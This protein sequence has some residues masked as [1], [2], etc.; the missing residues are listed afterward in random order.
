MKRTQT[1]P[2]TLAALSGLFDDTVALFHRLTA[3]AEQVHGQGGLSAARRGV[4]RSLDRLGPQTVPQMARARPVSR[5]LIQSLVNE[6]RRE[7]Y[8]ELTANP[9]HRRSS[10]V[11]LTRRGKVLVDAMGSR[12]LRLLKKLAIPVTERE[13]AGASSV[14]RSVREALESVRWKAIVAK[15]D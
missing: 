6:L 2:A 8:V 12:E 14:L 10:L 5:Q 3:V 7:G 4:L 15:Y 11:R 1:T 9:A 13:L